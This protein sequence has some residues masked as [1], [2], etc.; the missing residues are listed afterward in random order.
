MTKIQIK[1]RWT[2]EIIYEYKKEDNTIKETVEKA[3][4]EQKNL[5]RTYL[6]GAD[7]YLWDDEEPNI[8]KVIKEFEEKSNVK[9]KSYY[10]NKHMLSPYYLLYWKNALIIDDYEIVKSQKE[11][12]KMTV[13]EICKQLGYDVEIIKEEE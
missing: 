11:T 1:N 2:N 7:L 9:I 6:R 10:I 3:I 5:S 12:K 8:S 4:K 13:S